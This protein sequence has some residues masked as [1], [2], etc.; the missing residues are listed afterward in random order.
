VD[1]CARYGGEEIVILLPQ[2]SPQ[3]AVELADRLR[4]TIESRPAKSGVA[5][6]PITASFGVASYPSP[7]PYGDWLVLAADKAL[8]EAKAAGRNCVKLIHPNNVTPALYK[9]P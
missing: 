2:T 8:Y 1:L 7:V 5:E 4:Q 6:I 9:S 3:G